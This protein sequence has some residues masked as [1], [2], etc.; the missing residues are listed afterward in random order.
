MYKH[1]V[2]SN[3]TFTR[4]II[5]NLS[6][7]HYVGGLL[8]DYTDRFTIIGEQ[9]RV[10]LVVQVARFFYVAGGPHT[11]SVLRDS[12]FTR[13]HAIFHNANLTTMYI[14]VYT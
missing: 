13:M 14:H 4:Y 3:V 6:I 1:C 12:K 11:V 8:T 2:Q 9:E 5:V 7:I 10:N